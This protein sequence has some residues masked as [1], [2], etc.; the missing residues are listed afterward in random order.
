MPSLL[1]SISA[2]AS[3]LISTNN[4]KYTHFTQILDFLQY[5]LS[6][7]PS[8]LAIY[9]GPAAN[10]PLINVSAPMSHLV[11]TGEGKYAEIQQNASIT[12]DHLF[13][14]DEEIREKFFTGSEQDTESQHST[15]C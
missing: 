3:M 14:L 7:H 8:T 13:D 2:C 4:L 5:S 11:L 12:F 1:G 6:R 10:N 15:E 9:I